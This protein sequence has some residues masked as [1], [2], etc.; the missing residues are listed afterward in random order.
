MHVADLKVTESFHHNMSHFKYCQSTGKVIPVHTVQAY[1]GVEGK[2]HSFC[3]FVLEGH[4]WQTSCPTCFTKLSPL[5]KIL[6]PIN[7][8]GGEAPQN[9]WILWRREKSLAPSQTLKCS[10]HS[11]A[12]IVTRL[13]WLYFKK[14]VMLHCSGMSCCGSTGLSISFFVL[15]FL[16]VSSIKT[17]VHHI[18]KLSTNFQEEPG[19]N[20]N[21]KQHTSQ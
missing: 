1:G 6:V 3:T 18:M 2:L 7:L 12:T 16:C 20:P 8:V 14:Y 11:L 17:F 15:W 5:E 19:F 9:V 10:V 4:E 21:S 13:S